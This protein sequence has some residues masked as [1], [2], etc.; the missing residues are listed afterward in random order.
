M[1]G[2]RL[3]A[4]LGPPTIAEL[5][6]R[7]RAQRDAT[8]ALPTSVAAAQQQ[9]LDEERIARNA[10]L[11]GRTKAFGRALGVA[12]AGL[13]MA[14]FFPQLAKTVVQDVLTPPETE[15]EVQA[16]RGILENRGGPGAYQQALADARASKKA[17]QPGAKTLDAINPLPM[18]SGLAQG[19]L[20]GDPEAQGEATGL[21]GALVLGAVRGMAEPSRAATLTE[22]LNRVRAARQARLDAEAGSAPQ[23]PP[24]FLRRGG[25]V[26]T[27]PEGEVV[28]ARRPAPQ[29]RRA[30]A[31][32]QTLE[33]P[34][35]LRR[36]TL[37]IPPELKAKIQSGEAQY[38]YTGLDPR[39][40]KG[41]SAVGAGA[42]VGATVGAGSDKDHPL[43][44]AVLG[45]LA[46]ALGGGLISKALRA[47]RGGAGEAP[48]T[49]PSPFPTE[50]RPAARPGGLPVEPP[51]TPSDFVNTA[52]FDMDPTGKVRLEAEVE[53]VVNQLGMSPKRVVTWAEL[54]E[55]AAKLGVDF[56]EGNRPTST[57]MSAPQMLAIRNVVSA[58]V[59]ELERLSGE[60]VKPALTTP[61]RQA[62]DGRLRAIEG[63]NAHLLDR[64]IRSRSEA[65]RDLNSLKVIA[66]R[67]LDPTYWYTKAQT[68]KGAPLTADEQVNIRRLGEARDRAGLAQYVSGLKKAG[69]GQQLLT[70]W[71]TGLLTNPK[72]HIVNGVGNTTFGLMETAKDPV[73]AMVDRLLQLFTGERTKGGISR[74]TMEAS[75]RGAKAGLQEAKDILRGR[76]NPAQVAKLEL[77][78][79]VSFHNVLLDTYTKTVFGL[80]EAGDRPFY[81]AALFRSLAEQAEVAGKKMGLRGV[82]LREYVEGIQKGEGPLADELVAQAISDANVATFKDRTKLGEAARSFAKTVPGGEV[83]LPFQRTPGAV[84]T[85]VLEY[86]PLGLARGMKNAIE[87]GLKGTGASPA[88]QRAASE[89][90]ARG[91]VGSGAVWLG[92]E[93]AK[94]DL[95]T[96]AAPTMGSKE[97][98]LWMQ[99]NRQA[100]S[101]LINGQ[102]VNIGRLSPA[103]NLLALGANLYR[104]AQQPGA[105]DLATQMINVGAGALKTVADQPFLTG[106]SSALSAIQNPE[107]EGANF[108][109]GLAGSV[110]PAAVGAVARG[111]DVPRVPQVGTGPVS[112]VAGAV[113]ER[114]PGLRKTLPPRISTLGNRLPAPGW[115]NAIFNPVA[116]SPDLRASD[117]LIHELAEARYAVPRPPRQ[118]HE[119]P[120]DYAARSKLYGVAARQVLTQVVQ[121]EAYAAARAREQD[122]LAQAAALRKDPTFRAIPVEDLASAILAQIR[123]QDPQAKVRAEV[124]G[125]AVAA[126]RRQLKAAIQ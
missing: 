2:P 103:G 51:I 73:A 82:T 19:I 100:N 57:R 15:A 66:N 31:I 30:P 96:G 123:Q 25:A 109:R 42:V 24:T 120:A 48:T 12:K 106:A 39:L 45:G 116:A 125:D 20:E 75:A 1:T 72:T 4:D 62:L 23:I 122:A 97:R 53:R 67:V 36:Q 33:T 71:K 32:P 115:V 3:D 52:K 43:R 41:A 8:A 80:L 55:T 74:L 27:S 13:G 91:L 108:V 126:V 61:E 49:P 18:V 89:Q 63:Q 46:G 118:A 86:S 83:I 78:P 102:W 101:L 44:G 105:N 110:V 64:F 65:G 111:T 85:R 40:A 54:R 124:L 38:L 90:V 92:Y 112:G 50:V 37:Q 60:L 87:V 26:T 58:N 14:E 81:Q 7:L 114:I 5:L 59:A 17:S 28:L 70:L 69:L 76:P 121:S 95:M 104:A 21:A 10:R 94:H 79:D 113:T 119:T 99:E 107:R 93:L 84:A 35:V 29:P 11:P 98:Q 34:A 88:L 22:R 47:R 16:S 56:S 68:W 77:R 6:A 9:R 117:P